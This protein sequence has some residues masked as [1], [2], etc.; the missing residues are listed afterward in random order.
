MRKGGI[1]VTTQDFLPMTWSEIKE[2][3]IDFWSIK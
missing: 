2:G 3:D 1:F